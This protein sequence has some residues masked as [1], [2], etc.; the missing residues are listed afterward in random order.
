[1]ANRAFLQPT[2]VREPSQ[3][4]FTYLPVVKLYEA[5]TAA[6]LED[7]MS[8]DFG[9]NQQSITEYWVVEEIKYEVVVTAMKSG[10]TPAELL[11]SAL[12]WATKVEII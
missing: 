4:D 7:L 12:V 6:A 9:I 10:M 1:M 11:Y 2:T 8:V 3:G 5:T